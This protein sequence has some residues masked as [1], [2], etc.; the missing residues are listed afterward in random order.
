MTPD[1]ATLYRGDQVEEITEDG[2]PYLAETRHFLD[3]VQAGRQ[4]DIPI[5][6]GLDSLRLAH[7][8]MEGAAL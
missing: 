4:T 5:R 6:Q 8:I 1:A 2:D 3:C 7:T